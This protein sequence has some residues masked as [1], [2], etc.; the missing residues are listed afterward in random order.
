MIKKENEKMILSNVKEV[1]QYGELQHYTTSITIE[2]LSDVFGS[3]TYDP[4]AQRG[5]I[6]GKS[7]IDE[8]HVKEIYDNILNE[9]S[10]RG[11]LSWN[12]RYIEGECNFLYGDK[13]EM[14]TINENQLITIPD[15]AHRHEAIKR[16]A[17][18]VKDKRILK[19]QF[20]LDIYNLDFEEEKDLFHSINGKGKTPTKNRILYLSN[21]IRTSLVRDLIKK[22]SLKGRVETVRSSTR[23]KNLVKFSTIYDSLFGARG[24]Y[25]KVDINK[26]NYDEH[27]NWFSSF[28]TELLTTREDFQY[29]STKERREIKLKSMALEEITWWGYACLL[30][31][32]E[33]S[34][35][36]KKKLNSMMNKSVKVE[37][38]KSIDF[39]SK[40]NPIWHAT[41]I[42]PRYD[43]VTQRQV[44]GTSVT[45]SNSTRDSMKKIFDLTLT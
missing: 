40:I 10:I 12:L 6:E 8:K 4:D 35:S 33:D 41:V 11:S 32:I 1:I 42:K 28:Y 15:S 43:Y 38:G 9:I 25:S 39:L 23:G 37:G 34:K 2:E 14:L 18:T 13:H 44:L 5:E 24:V 16:I 20:S 29:I 36:W 21:D 17:E 31:D 3:L 27:L 7:E 26:E 19:S 30:K 22:S 45:N